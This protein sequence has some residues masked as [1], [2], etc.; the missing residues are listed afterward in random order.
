MAESKLDRSMEHSTDDSF[1]AKGSLSVG[2][3]V[4]K[5]ATGFLDE[6]KDQQS[7]SNIP[8]SP[9]WLY[10][11]PTES[12]DGRPQ[13][14][15]EAPQENKRERRRINN[16]NTTL[17]SRWREEERET[18][19]LGRRAGSDRSNSKK[20][21]ANSNPN[22]NPNP[23]NTSTKWSSRWG[24]DDR[25]DNKKAPP[26]DISAEKEHHHH[27]PTNPNPNPNFAL[28]PL[29][30]ADSRD[31]WRPRH[32]QENSNPNPSRGAPGFGSERGG[33][34]QTQTTRQEAVTNVGF[35]PGRGRAGSS[36]YGR[37]RG[38]VG[39]SG[40]RYPR[41]KLLD[42]YRKNGPGGLNDENA[43]GFRRAEG[44]TLPNPVPP[45]AF[46]APGDEEE[47]TL[48]EIYKGKVT[49]ADANGPNQS[50]VKA[51]GSSQID[52]GLLALGEEKYALPASLSVENSPAVLDTKSNAAFPNDLIEDP[53]SE[54]TEKPSK[55]SMLS[56]LNLESVDLGPAF[57]AA[58]M[59]LPDDS[60]SLFDSSF[61]RGEALEEEEPNPNPNPNS[62]PLEEMS[63]FYRDPQ[64]GVQGPFL[65]IDIMSWFEEG[66][67]GLDL[68]ICPSDA[69]EGTPYRPLADVMP[70]LVRNSQ[71]VPV[72]VGQPNDA[73]LAQLGHGGSG[74]SFDYGASKMAN[75]G[76]MIEGNLE[77]GI[78]SKFD[79]QWNQN[80]DSEEIIYAGRPRSGMGKPQHINQTNEMTDLPPW[81][82]NP[83]PELGDSS[84]RHE[85]P[86]QREPNSNNPNDNITPLGLLW[87]ELE[88]PHSKHPLSSN[89]PSNYRKQQPELNLNLNPMKQ[90]QEISH[91][92]LEEQLLNEQLQRQQMQ[93][94]QQEQ[95]FMRAGRGLGP[96][97]ASELEQLLKLQY[98][99]EQQRQM[100][101]KQ[102][103]LKQQQQ[104]EQQRREQMLR[105]QKIQEQL[106]LEQIL[107]EQQLQ[108][109]QMIREQ[110]FL[111]ELQIAQAQQL[112]RQQ[113]DAAIE[114][115]IQAKFGPAGQRQMISPTIEQQILLGLQQRD[116]I[117]AQQLALALRQ[118]QQQQQQEQQRLE[119][120]MLLRGVRG[121]PSLHRTN[122]S[123]VSQL[124]R[125]LSLHDQL[126]SM[127]RSLS[128]N[129]GP[130]MQSPRNDF[131]Q[132]LLQGLE[133]QERERQ[134][135]ERQ[136]QERQLQERQLQER[137]QRAALFGAGPMDRFWDPNSNP[138]PNQL[139]RNLIESQLNHQMQLEA[140]NQRRTEIQQ[141]RG[142]PKPGLTL[143]DPHPLNEM[144]YQN[145]PLQS[146]H[147]SFKDP[148]MLFPRRNPSPNPNNPSSG[149]GVN[150][151]GMQ[152]GFVRPGSGSGSR[153]GSFVEKQFYGNFNEF[154]NE[155]VGNVNVNVN[156][157]SFFDNLNE[158]QNQEMVR[159][160]TPPARLASVGSTD[161]VIFKYEMG[162]DNANAFSEET[163]DTRQH[164]ISRADSRTGASQKQNE[165]DQQMNNAPRPPSRPTSA[166]AAKQEV[167]TGPHASE[168]QS[169]KKDAPKLLRNPSSSGAESDAS[170]R[171]FI[172][173]LK[174][175]KKPPQ[176]AP[177]Q[178]DDSA[179]A[180]KGAKKGKKKGRQIDP[181]LLGFKVHSNRI[182]MGEIQRP[183][184]S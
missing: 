159:A 45:L 179:E 150:I 64:G 51:V 67:F 95:M 136:L 96:Q 72:P 123:R 177:Q 144:L 114:Q 109:Q 5:S 113:Q 53:F 59:N 27:E 156:D 2:L 169:T 38:D 171:S 116:P 77:G 89:L 50:P 131:A 11:K 75:D 145:M 54:I 36:V 140:E 181:A 182:M 42:I 85:I 110:Q 101:I 40:F 20:D 33:A 167:R 163:I 69:V 124:E 35:A 133:L 24:P 135:Q 115:L 170:G 128:M 164:G 161:D 102:Q 88:S 87:S 166:D 91:F 65:G 18:G 60:T 12:K 23:S 117:Q 13:G 165:T 138:N 93:Q 48:E 180:S 148:S 126:Q 175:T 44:F 152:T 56:K 119:E 49:G 4:E 32:R 139:E 22:P 30:E 120:E 130:A 149:A 28:R 125:S 57:N 172:D 8:L 99:I 17:D 46:V 132:T 112:H 7:E 160:P 141:R 79:D 168:T 83:V 66:Y 74:G 108:E 55:Q 16:S 107:R 41:G 81:A 118:Q 146:P 154:Q 103:Q 31:K 26:A 73:E 86:V 82:S 25:S 155:E 37:G 3:D 21:S 9:Q 98:E 121:G 137:Q 10:A 106:M 84:L 173:M 134:L 94:I 105:Q 76:M 1:A 162:D 100:Q 61:I 151:E 143:D 158:F 52:P 47:V 147:G 104:Q 174:S 39:K 15:F 71:P 43:P 90:Q 183:D 122:S 29:S 34:G 70:H 78:N 68:P 92:A 58:S 6:F 142:I 176:P 129:A 184:E 157:G 80:V 62:I 127:E 153:P 63:F 14:I 178:A 97:Q 19:L 111:K